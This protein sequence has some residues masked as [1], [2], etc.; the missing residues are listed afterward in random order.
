MDMQRQ[1]N[2]DAIR[3]E[4][5]KQYSKQARFLWIYFRKIPDALFM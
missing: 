3:Q 5:V 4:L 2:G 1:F